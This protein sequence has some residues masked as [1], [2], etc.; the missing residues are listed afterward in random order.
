MNRSLSARRPLL[1]TV[2]TTPETHFRGAPYP[3]ERRNPLSQADSSIAKGKPTLLIVDDEHLIADTLAEILGDKGFQVTAVYDGRSALQHIHKFCPDILITDVVMPG[4]SG[5]ELA[6][7]V[8][9]MCPTTRIVLLSGQAGTAEL[10]ER[11]RREGHSFELLS[12]PIG[13][14]ALLERLREK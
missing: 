5:I 8:R 3:P 14:E 10:V 9:S 4:M 11:A 1:A 7:A 6:T 12:K 2:V 13:P